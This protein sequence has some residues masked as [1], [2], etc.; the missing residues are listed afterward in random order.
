MRRSASG[1]AKYCVTSS[2]QLRISLPWVRAD[3]DQRVSARLR[4]ASQEFSSADASSIMSATARPVDRAP[5]PPPLPASLHSSRLRRTKQAAKT[6][7]P[8]P[9]YVD[10]YDDYSSKFTML[11]KY[12]DPVRLK[13]LDGLRGGA[14]ADLSPS[15][16]WPPSPARQVMAPFLDSSKNVAWLAGGF[17]VAEVWERSLRCAIGGLDV[18]V[19][20]DEEG[21]G[22]AEGMVVD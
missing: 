17:K 2:V 21:E 12:L 1:E 6:N 8:P 20:R 11:D 9:P 15:P 5:S 4:H 13:P 10:P 16:L 22:G 19:L 18:D 14:L 7:E 3:A